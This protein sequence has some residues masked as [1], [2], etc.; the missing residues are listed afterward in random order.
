MV[1][2]GH[3]LGKSP[4]AMTMLVA[5]SRINRPMMTTPE[6]ARTCLDTIPPLATT[7]GTATRLA[8]KAAIVSTPHGLELAWLGMRASLERRG[9]TRRRRQRGGNC[10]SKKKNASRFAGRWF[11]NEFPGWGQRREARVVFRV[12]P[13]DLNSRGGVALDGA[14]CRRDRGTGY[15]SRGLCRETL[16]RTR[17]WEQRKHPFVSG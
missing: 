4:F 10:R 12:E 17:P 9:R 14:C 13:V 7:T 6:T 1:P 2:A 8:Q 16:P 5:L 15:T 11:D 3:A